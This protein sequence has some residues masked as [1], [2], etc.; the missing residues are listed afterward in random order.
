MKNTNIKL[1]KAKCEKLKDLLESVDSKNRDVVWNQL[2]QEVKAVNDIWNQIDLRN[3]H[4]TKIRKINPLK[5]KT[6][7]KMESK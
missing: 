5:N 3:E 6:K 4:M 1:N 7:I 2:Y